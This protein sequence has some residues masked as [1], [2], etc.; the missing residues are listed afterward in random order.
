VG[1]VYARTHS[2]TGGLLQIWLLRRF[3]TLLSFQPILLGLIFLSRKFWI[4]G[5]VLCG[6]GLFVIVFVEIYVITRTRQPGRGS[7][8]AITR[9]SL[10]AITRDSLSSFAA[11][12]DGGR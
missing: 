10:P 11:T 6:T 3:G 2:Q 4:E 8:P 7:L 12:T 5:G 1:Y 9:G